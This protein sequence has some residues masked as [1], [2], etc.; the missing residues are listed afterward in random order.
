MSWYIVDRMGGGE[1]ED[2]ADPSV[3]RMRFQLQSLDPNDEEHGSV[4]L[5]HRESGWG[6]AYFGDRLILEN[7]SASDSPKHMVG[8]SLEK[9]LELWQVL[10]QGDIEELMQERWKPGYA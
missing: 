4:S 3:E 6:L 1:K 7:P 9:A 8:V 5:Q 2:R 10:A